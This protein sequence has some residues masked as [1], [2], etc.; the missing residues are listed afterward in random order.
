MKE[1]IMILITDQNGIIINEQN[2]KGVKLL[3]TK[4]ENQE[5][6]INFIIIDKTDYI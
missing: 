5:S 2:R 1:T 4:E 3:L 6:A